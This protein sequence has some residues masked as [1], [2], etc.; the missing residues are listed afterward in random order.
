MALTETVPTKFPEQEVKMMDKL[1]ERGIF[2]SRSDLIREA[3]R[4][5][6]K[7][8]MQAKTYGDVLVKKM[9]EEGDFD[10]IEWKT[11]VNV[12]LNPE[13]DE[14]S[15]SEAEKKAVRKLFRDPMGLLKRQEK[16]LVVTRNGE[17]IVKGY[18]KALLHSKTV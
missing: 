11:L 10:K 9:K 1:I 3:T 6:M 8:S 2:I 16:R 18:I 13:F 12:Y 15:M 5:K 17:S 7:Y 4:E 14:N